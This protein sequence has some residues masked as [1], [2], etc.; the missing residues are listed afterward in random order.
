MERCVDEETEDAFQAQDERRAHDR[1]RLILDVFFDGEDVTDV[2]SSKDISAGG[3]YM[4]TQA[5]IPV[6]ALLLVPRE[7]DERRVS[8]HGGGILAAARDREQILTGGDDGKVVATDAG[9][10]ST[11]IATDAKRRWIDRVAVGP[12]GALPWSAGKQAFVQTGTSEPKSIEVQS[13]AG[14]IAF[15][16]KGV[17]L[18]IAH[19]NGVSM[20]F[21]NAQ[22]A[23]EFL[24]WKGS[25]HHPAFS[26]NGQF[27]V[28]SM[29]EPA[30]HGWRAEVFGRD[31]LRLVQGEV[32]LSARGG[33]VR[34]VNVA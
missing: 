2:A 34:V 7:G 12:G 30:L 15:A 9:G 5:T 8:V 19:Y 10:K 11:V 31:A 6:G 29:Q 28:T 25:H 13:T 18:A 24:E 23:P 20:W 33:A 1:S 17:R 14:G 22:A 4:T 26:P 32:A 3:L 16:P 21:P 27:L